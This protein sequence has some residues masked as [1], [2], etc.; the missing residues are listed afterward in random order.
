MSYPRS[1]DLQGYILNLSG[2]ELGHIRVIR[3]S[4]NRGAHTYW[5]CKCVC[6]KEWEVRGSLI[7]RRIIESCGCKSKSIKHNMW[8]TRE[9]AAWQTMVARCEN[10]NVKNYPNY[11][12]RG[13]KVCHRWRKS[14]KNFISDMGRRPTSRH[15]LDR[16]NNDEDYSPT[17][18]RWA[19]PKEQGRN[20]RTNNLITIDGETKTLT[21]WMEV[22]GISKGGVHYRVKRKGWTYEKALTEPSNRESKC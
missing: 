19:T 5:L 10:E 18:C 12:G 6:G 13:I 14:F 3:R 8:K 15:S 7:Q 16:I 4:D 1:E 22:Y 11:G 17:N 21:D 20:R 2:Q 9:F